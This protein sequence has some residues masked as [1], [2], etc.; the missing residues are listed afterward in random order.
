MKLFSTIS[1][2]QANANPNHN[3]ILLSDSYIFPYHIFKMH[4]FC[5]CHSV[6]Q[7]CLTLCDPMDCRTPGY[8]LLALSPGILSP[9]KFIESM[10]PSNHLILYCP[11]SSCPQSF[12]ASGYFQMSQLFASYGQSI[13]AS[14]SASIVPMNI[15]GW[16]PLGL[17]GLISLLSKGLWRVFSRTTVQK[18]QFFGPQPFFIVQLSHLLGS[19]SGL[20]RALGEGNGYPLQYSGLENSMDCLLHGVT[21]SQTQLSDFHFYICT[22]LLK[23][24]IA[25]TIWTL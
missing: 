21:K 7:L 3:E 19:I 2:H 6:T 5:C 18:H 9:G 25:L 14:A 24:N 17:T 4:C 12:L 8:Y 23:K 22:W 20:E 13:E 11:F 1:N 10:M 16:F 15:Q